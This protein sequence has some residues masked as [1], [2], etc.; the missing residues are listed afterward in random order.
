MATAKIQ[1][2]GVFPSAGLPQISIED[3]NKVLSVVNGKWGVVEC[4]IKN[5][6]TLTIDEKVPKSLSILPPI[7]DEQ[8]KTSEVRESSRI[9]VDVDG[10]PSFATMKQ[11]K[12]LNTK[13]IFVDKLTDEKINTLS[14]DDIILLKE[15]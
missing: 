15:R 1:V 13:T 5:E 11:I 2:L 12:E 3:N 4:P 6:L 8:F 10:I 9:Y 14:N 7:S